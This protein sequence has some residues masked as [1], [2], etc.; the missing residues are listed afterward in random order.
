MNRWPQW[1]VLTAVL[2][3][4]FP[5]LAMT[6][7]VAGV[8]GGRLVACA[9]PNNLPF[10]N[11]A[12]Q[13]FENE[14]AELVA[15]K[16]HMQLRYTWWAQRRGFIRNTLNDTKCDVWLGVAHGVGRVTTTRPYYRSSYMFVTRA[17][18]PLAGLTLDDRR[19]TSLLIGVQ[20]IGN[21]AMNTPPAHAVAVRGMTD[22]VR[23]Y[24][25]YG[26]YVQPNPAAAIIDAVANK[27]VDVAIVWGP[28][29]GYFAKRS[30]VALRLEPVTPAHEPT[31]PMIYDISMGVR[32]DNEVLRE[33]LDAFLSKEAPAIDE[34]LRQYGIPRLPLSP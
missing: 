4:A 20:M 10:S 17:D 12:Q 6:S 31:S 7:A 3:L 18:A 11:R 22:N 30:P 27:H 34:I 16:F 2:G 14:I 8:R 15:K 9:D 5:N 25:V 19:L 1:V 23:G 21:D 32:R 29:A 26:N 24:M 13:G 28:L 33:R